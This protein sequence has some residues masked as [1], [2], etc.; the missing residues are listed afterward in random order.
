MRSSICAQSAASTPPAWELIV[1]SASRA[2]YGPESSVRTSRALTS[3]RR[4]ASSRP[5]SSRVSA[6]SSASASS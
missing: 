2:S 6:S 1:M 4:E 3:V 5:A